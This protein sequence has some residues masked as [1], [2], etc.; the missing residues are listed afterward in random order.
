[1]AFIKHVVAE[2]R[3]AHSSSSQTPAFPVSVEGGFHITEAMVAV[4]YLGGGRYSG[5]ECLNMCVE[6]RNVLPI[7]ISHSS[8]QHTHIAMFVFQMDHCTGYIC[9]I[10]H[11]PPCFCIVRR[12]H[13]ILN[14]V[15]NFQIRSPI[16]SVS[17]ER[18][19]A[20]QQL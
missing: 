12:Y 14:F 2:I 11:N 5:R 17:E 3:Q 9:N 18:I 1:M 13:A 6:L 16:C 4:R 7:N 10:R 19:D 20:R 8:S 15:S